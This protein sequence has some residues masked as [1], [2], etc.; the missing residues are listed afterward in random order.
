[1]TQDMKTNRTTSLNPMNIVVASLAGLVAGAH[2]AYLCSTIYDELSTMDDRELGSRGIARDEIPR[3]V[4]A[5]TGLLPRHEENADED[6]DAEGRHAEWD[7]AS[8]PRSWH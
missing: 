4:A 8:P 7:E 5:A 3:V 2:K 6:A 1:M